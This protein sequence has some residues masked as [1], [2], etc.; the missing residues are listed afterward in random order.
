MAGKLPDLNKLGK[1][2]EIES[3]YVGISD[4]GVLTVD[5]SIH[6]P[7]KAKSESTWENYKEV[8]TDLDK[9]LDRVK[10]IYTAKI[11]RHK[12]YKNLPMAESAK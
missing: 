2:I 9:A 6:K 11:K 8:F 12:N 10:E 5:W 4:N 3:V 1:D 7:R